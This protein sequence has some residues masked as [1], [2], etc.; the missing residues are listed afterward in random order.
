MSSER[1]A[2]ER[3]W[4]ECRR[5][6]CRRPERV[7]SRHDAHWVCTDRPWCDRV[8]LWREEQQALADELGKGR[9]MDPPKKKIP[10]K[11]KA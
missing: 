2:Y 9:K 6:H 5:C 1:E 3:D 7:L 8:V 11:R 4:H 10:L